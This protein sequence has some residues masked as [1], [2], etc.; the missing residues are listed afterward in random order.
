M[1]KI[2]SYILAASLLLGSVPVVAQ[3]IPNKVTINVGETVDLGND[4]AYWTSCNEN[5]VRVNQDGEITG[6]R[7]GKTTVA[8]RV[9]IDVHKSQVTVI[10]PTM[11]LSKKEVTLY[12]GGPSVKLKVTTKG[13]SKEVH[14][15]SSNELVATVDS[16]GN[17]KPVNDGVSKIYVESNDLKDYCTVVVNKTSIELDVMDITLSTSGVGSSI[18]LNP[19]V[20][21]KSSKVKYS[22][23]NKSIATVSSKGVVKGKNT[24][25]AVITATANGVSTSC[26]VTVNKGNI[27]INEEKLT[28]YTNESKQLKTNASK[29]EKIQWASS[30][31]SVVSVDASGKLYAEGPGTAV[32][33]VSG[34]TTSDSCYVDVLESSTQIGEDTVELSTKGENKTY[35]LG[36]KIIGRKPK[37]KWVSSDTDVVTVNSKG[38]LTAKSRGRAKVMATANGVVDTVTVVVNEY[39]PSTKLNYD[40]YVLY[41]GKGNKVTLK[42]SV[43][44]SSKAVTW[45][46]SNPEVAVVSGGKVT[47]LGDGVA[48]VTAEANGV[49]D[50]CTVEVKEN[51][52]VVI[53]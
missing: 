44:G 26:S 16:Q 11:K 27:S 29:N 37:V 28:L 8:A 19:T 6:A 48:I 41:T 45:N 43:D 49:V 12:E 5:T 47:A 22:T 15:S 35:T 23:S 53:K 46:S 36:L 14:F 50:S 38:K 24:G 34:N 13:S 42:A 17:I 10:N 30:D 40:S 32:I 7:V 33:T 25:T 31:R 9:G 39:K 51:G 52:V 18:K 1:Y 3:S 2:L 20:S 21:G 4:D